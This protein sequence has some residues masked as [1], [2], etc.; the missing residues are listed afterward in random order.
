MAAQKVKKVS[1]KGGKKGGKKGAKQGTAGRKPKMQKRGFRTYIY[2]VL[3]AQHKPTGIGISSKSMLIM[4]N[5]MQDVLQRLAGESVHLLRYNGKA[6]IT[7]KEVQT[8]T[9]LV[10]PG[11]IAKHAVSEGTKA[12]TRYGMWKEDQQKKK[13]KT[14]A[15]PV[16]KSKAAGLQFPV[17]R[18]QRVLKEMN[19]K[20]VSP[21]AAVYMAASMEY[22]ASEILDVSSKAA[23]ANKRQRITPRHLQL[24]I[25][26]DE[27]LDHLLRNVTISSGGVLPN[28]HKNLLN[29]K[30]GQKEEE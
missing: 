2:K 25:R 20:N 11:E 14:K 15:K 12:V 5:C 9:R 7:T 28:I 1:K 3:K 27:E 10:M 13:S 30:P 8:A 29:R 6:T 21:R 17:G 19:I 23:V 22:V 24:G 4:D 16:S 26:N 18:V